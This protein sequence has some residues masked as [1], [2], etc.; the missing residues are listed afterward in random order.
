[1]KSLFVCVF[2]FEKYVCDWFVDEFCLTGL[3]KN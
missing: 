3:K 1:M 2:V